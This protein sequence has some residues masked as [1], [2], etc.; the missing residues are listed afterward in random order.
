MMYGSFAK[1]LFIFSFL[2]LLPL[3]DFDAHPSFTVFSFGAGFIGSL[4][5]IRMLGSS[6]DSM[7]D[8]AKGLMKYIFFL[9][10]QMFMV[11]NVL[12][13][14]SYPWCHTSSLLLSPIPF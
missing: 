3:R 9:C 13:Y 10:S 12:Y 5:Y 14:I 7:A 6:V 1:K 2:S 11:F 4:V 8:G